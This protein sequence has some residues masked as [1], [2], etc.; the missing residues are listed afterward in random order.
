MGGRFA[1]D[2]LLGK[3]NRIV[4]GD[5][6]ADA[7]GRTGVRRD[8]RVNAD[9]FA[10]GINQR[11]A[12]IARI[13]GRI[14]LNHV[15]VDH[16]F[17]RGGVLHGIRTLQCTHHAGRHRVFQTERA[18]KR[19]DPLAHLQIGRTANFDRRQIVGIDLN[20]R[21]VARR[22]AAHDLRVVF[23]AIH[24]R[25]NGVSAL[26]HVVVRDDIS[27][28]RNHNATAERCIGKRGIVI[29]SRHF[30]AIH[31]ARRRALGIDVDAHDRGQAFLRHLLGKRRGITRIIGRSR[32]HRACRGAKRSR[33]PVTT[34][35]RTVAGKPASTKHQRKRGAA[36]ARRERFTEAPL[37]VGVGL[38][39]RFGIRFALSLARLLSGIYGILVRLLLIGLLAIGLLILRRRGVCAL[40]VL[41]GLRNLSVPGINR[42]REVFILVGHLNH[43]L[44]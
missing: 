6:K 3:V 1:F 2:N 32:N 18:A 22:V 16:R 29:G 10:L 5:R 8:H 14:G 37:H 25:L 24:G 41:L 20:H 13:N 11:T 26:D 15:R 9:Q 34:R 4:D 28:F 43:S 27:I 12:R 35:K 44:S 39:S 31:R 40:R 33:T 21:D 17:A 7:R 36:K 19:H 38:V 30:E 42:T 23:H